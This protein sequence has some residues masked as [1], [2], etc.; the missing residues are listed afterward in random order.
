MSLVFV[1]AAYL[2]YP[3]SSEIRQISQEVARNLSVLMKILSDSANEYII[4]EA[5][6]RVYAALT[7]S[8]IKPTNTGNKLDVLVY[9]TARLIVEKIGNPRLREY[10]AEVESKS[11]NKFLGSESESFLVNLA[12]SSFDWSVESMGDT[13][14]RAQLPPF[15]R[16][17]ELKMRFEDFLEIAH[18][19][20]A[21]EWKLTNRYV[22]DGWVPIRKSELC[23]LMSEKFKQL[24][25]SSTLNPPNLPARITESILRIESEL[26]TK[27]KSTEPVKIEGQVVSAFPP[28]IELVHNDSIRGKN[29]AHDARFMLASF[30]LKIGM[31]EDEVLGVFKPSPDFRGSLAEYQIRQ[32][33]SKSQGEG[34]TPPGCRK[35]QSNGF[36]PLY[37][38]S[39]W[40]PLC[41]YVIHPLSFYNTRAW[42]ITQGIDDHSWYTRSDKMKKKQNL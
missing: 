10:Q 9:T 41:E 34:Y 40:D 27:L 37:N 14:A 22:D 29:L 26:G 38:R 30:L 17:Y 24:I 16:S 31:D 42:E 28:C 2:K 21:K 18:N 23:R 11:V 12:K 33:A 13:R 8:E 5:E 6:K 19:F 1:E 36:C 25:L 4:E 20:R 7:Q 39:A 15:L 32:I 35:I 3:F